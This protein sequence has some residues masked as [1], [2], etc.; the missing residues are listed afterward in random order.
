MIDQ[1]P[2]KIFVQLRSIIRIAE[3]AYSLDDRY[4]VFVE[5][6]IYKMKMGDIFQ[7]KSLEKCVQYDQNSWDSQVTKSS[8]V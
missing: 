4:T 1:D 8:E 3:V 6:T 7:M 5:R 2:L